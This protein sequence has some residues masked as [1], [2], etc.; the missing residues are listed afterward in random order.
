MSLIRAMAAC[1]GVAMSTVLAL[2]QPAPAPT[3]GAPAATRTVN[4][5]AE[6]RHIIKEIVLKEIKVEK[7]PA[8][9]DITVGAAVP[10]SVSLHQFPPDVTQKVPQVKAHSFF[11][12]DDQVVV[13]SPT[14]NTITEVIK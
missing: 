2:A 4:L 12:K 9:V 6:Q 10:E 11:V 14:S 13:V 3:P 1:A 5:T 7:P 8:D